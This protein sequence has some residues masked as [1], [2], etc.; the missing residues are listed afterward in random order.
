MA[1]L[2]DGVP[3]DPEDLLAR[4]E[5]RADLLDR[6]FE[7]RPEATLISFKL[8]IPGCIKQSPFLD[9]MFDQALEKIRVLIEESELVDLIKASAGPEAV[10]ATGKGAE[11]VKRRMVALEETSP[12]GRLYDIDVMEQGRALTREWL[13]L[14]E[15][16]CFVCFSPARACARA[17]THSMAQLHQAMEELIRSDPDLAGLLQSAAECSL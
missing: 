3:V 2:D 1:F 17:R 13:G 8:S 4:R 9:Q 7:Q 5:Q 14:P 16:R 11:E 6:M 12:A 15:R 10:L